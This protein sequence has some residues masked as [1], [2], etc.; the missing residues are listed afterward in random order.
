MKIIYICILLL[1]PL[2]S[3]ET[4]RVNIET[5][6]NTVAIYTDEDEKN[7]FD[8]DREKESTI[9]LKADCDDLTRKLLSLCEKERDSAKELK[10]SLEKELVKK[11]MEIQGCV[12]SEIIEESCDKRIEIVENS[13]KEEDLKKEIKFR[14]NIII[15][16]LV[17]LFLLV[18]WG[19]K[20]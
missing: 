3:A 14:N 8:C 19:L 2:V 12:S 15:G 6:N 20:K 7:I 10:F 4:I 18:L 5:Y 9:R 16:L 17:L 1:I 11:D 13:C